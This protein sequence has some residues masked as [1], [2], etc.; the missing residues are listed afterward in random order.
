MKI[1]NRTPA[2]VMVSMAALPA[3]LL[4]SPALAETWRGVERLK[5]RDRVTVIVE[6]KTR[7]YFRATPEAPLTVPV[8]GPARVRL[9]SRAELPAGAQASSYRVRAMLG[10]KLLERQGT[11]S[12][13]S[14]DARLAKTPRAIGQSRQ[15]IVNVPKGEHELKVSIEGASSVLLR[16]LVSEGAGREERTVGLAPVEAARTVSLKENEKI[17]PYYSALPGKSIRFKVVGPASLD[18]V[19]RLDYDSSMRGSQSYRLAISDGS[20]RPREVEFK[21]TKALTAIYADLPELVPSKF[22]RLKL[23]VGEGTHEITVALLKPVT[24]SVE[25]QARIPEPWVGKAE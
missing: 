1:L 11:E 5:G 21:T 20:K 7:T 19:T 8:K 14:K 15:M 12:T 17:F 16:I 9:V 10:R 6:E 25:V 24:G 3:V 23:S 2:A 18:L 22:R 13:P 4:C